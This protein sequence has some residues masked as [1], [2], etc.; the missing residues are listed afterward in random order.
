MYDISNNCFELNNP[1]L[2]IDFSI[3]FIFMLLVIFF[4][5]KILKRF[6]VS[7]LLISGSIA[8]L[9]A[10]FFGLH[11]LWTILLF[12]N[13]V[14]LITALFVNIGEV[15]S[16]FSN[17]L[18][19]KNKLFMNKKIEKVFDRKA[20]YR[21]INDAVITLSRQR[22]GALIC[23]ERNTDLDDFIKSGTT[24]DASVSPELL[25][26]IFYNGT[27]LH[28]GAVIIRR[29]KIIAASVYFTPTTKPLTGKYGSRHRAAIGI[30]EMSDSITIIVS[31]ETG[32]IS[33]ANGGELTSVTADNFLRVLE[34]NMNERK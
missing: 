19:P 27:R 15:R 8:M 1:I 11:L 16:V 22:I 4:I 21:K 7:T 10:W 31:E 34:D 32:R 28:D 30:S 17:A 25:L 2:W 14:V 13:S 9:I 29:D 20:L 6:L 33:I 5:L 26:T 24:L 3:S 12:A 23:I 18:G